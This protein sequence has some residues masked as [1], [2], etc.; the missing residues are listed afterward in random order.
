MPR[1]RILAVAV[2]LALIVSALAPAVPALAAPTTGPISYE[3]QNRITV[4]NFPAK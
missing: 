1:S 3:L 4:I 2:T